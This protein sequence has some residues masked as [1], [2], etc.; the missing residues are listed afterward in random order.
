MVQKTTDFLRG[1]FDEHYH[2]KELADKLWLLM[3]TWDALLTNHKTIE[4]K[5]IRMEGGE[6]S[7]LYPILS[8]GINVHERGRD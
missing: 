3:K 6:K 2:T 5:G 7:T 8:F 4:V 1:K